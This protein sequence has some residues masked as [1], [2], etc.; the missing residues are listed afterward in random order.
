MFFSARDQR[1][2][3]SSE[4]ASITADL[5]CS[6]RGSY[7][8]SVTM[9]CINRAEGTVPG[10][11]DAAGAPAPWCLRNCGRLR[12]R[13][14][15]RYVTGTDVGEVAEVDGG[16]CDNREPLAHRDHGSVG[17]AQVP[18]SVASHEVSHAAQV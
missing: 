17:P 5:A 10:A 18:V 16:D 11:N 12:D 9:R 8:R 1:P 4:L 13:G 3:P 15:R 14:Q 2:W 7:L 6:C